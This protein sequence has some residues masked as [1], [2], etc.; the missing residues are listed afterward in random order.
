M[1]VISGHVIVEGHINTTLTENMTVVIKG[2]GHKV[3]TVGSRPSCYYY[4]FTNG[5]RIESTDRESK[6]MNNLLD[7]II[8]KFEIHSRC[9]YLVVNSWLNLVFDVPM[10]LRRRV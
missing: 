6:L 4:G 9:F 7:W 10:V 2:Q 8:E 1:G 3:H 5:S